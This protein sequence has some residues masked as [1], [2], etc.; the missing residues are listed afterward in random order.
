M[1]VIAVYF[2]FLYVLVSEGSEYYEKATSECDLCESDVSNWGS[3]P[4]S[5][6]YNDREVVLDCVSEICSNECSCVIL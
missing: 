5:D 4:L 1:R 3:I 6:I 2:L